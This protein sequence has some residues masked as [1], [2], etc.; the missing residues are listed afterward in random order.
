MDKMMKKIIITYFCSMN[1]VFIF[2]AS[3]CNAQDNGY[4]ENNK[5]KIKYSSNAILDDDFFKNYKEKYK[6][7][8]NIS[9]KIKEYTDEIFNLSGT[10]Y[11]PNRASWDN[12]HEIVN[13]KEIIGIGREC[14]V[15]ISYLADMITL[16][17]LIEEQDSN[18]KKIHYRI[19]NTIISLKFQIKSLNHTISISKNV[20]FQSLYLNLKDSLLEAKDIFEELKIQME[21]RYRRDKLD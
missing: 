11:D 12:L 21:E 14:S 2:L 16:F 10:L 19:E 6:K 3:L 13:V 20:G 4:I 8:I 5:D 7:L 15:R 9:D 18:F 17:T 1:V